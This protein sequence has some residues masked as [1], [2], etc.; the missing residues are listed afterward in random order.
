MTVNSSTCLALLAV[1][2]EVMSSEFSARFFL[3]SALPVV[4]EKVNRSFVCFS[5]MKS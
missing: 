3:H 1:L 4:F 5:F 2:Y